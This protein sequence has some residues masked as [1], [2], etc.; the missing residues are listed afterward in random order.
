MARVKAADLI[1]R[2]GRRAWAL[3][4]RLRPMT[5]SLLPVIVD[6]PMTA[7]RDPAASPCQGGHFGDIVRFEARHLRVKRV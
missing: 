7:S 1:H 5:L 4:G 6:L 2:R 3:L